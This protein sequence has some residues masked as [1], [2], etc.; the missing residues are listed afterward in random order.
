MQEW[1]GVRRRERCSG[2]RDAM[3]AVRMEVRRGCK[4]G[5]S[6]GVRVEDAVA[7][8]G[9]RPDR[10]ADWAQFGGQIDGAAQ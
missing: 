8:G 5:A 6:G 3:P 7:S 2:G 9:V 4:H 1:L 10:G